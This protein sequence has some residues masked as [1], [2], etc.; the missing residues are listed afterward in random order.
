MKRIISWSKE[1][2]INEESY[3]LSWENQR[4]GTAALKQGE[5]QNG[6]GID[7]QPKKLIHARN[8]GHLIIAWYYKDFSAWGSNGFH[9]WKANWHMS[10]S[11]NLNALT[12]KE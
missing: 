4:A 10:Q 3:C 8:G 5:K 12:E 2:E 6:N 11:N 1:E 7:D 9:L